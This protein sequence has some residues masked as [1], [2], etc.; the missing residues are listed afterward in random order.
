MGVLDY[1]VGSL[2]G[3]MSV[4]KLKSFE[5]VRKSMFKWYKYKRKIAIFA[6]FVFVDIQGRHLRCFF[7]NG[8]DDC[9]SFTLLGI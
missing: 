9:I 3:E 6:F 4:Y 2:W 7:S 1:F 5:N 8:K